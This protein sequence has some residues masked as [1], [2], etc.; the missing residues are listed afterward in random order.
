[1]R[2][3]DVVIVGA[4]LAGLCCALR[5]QERGVAC[6]IL[7]AGD[8]VGGRVRTDVVDGFLLDRGFQVLLTAYPEAQRV[9]DY[10]ALDLHA[11]YPGAMIRYG[12]RFVRFV[13]PTRRFWD[14]LRSAFAPIG[15]FNDKRLMLKLKKDVCRG[16]LD[17]LFRRPEITTLEALHAFGFSKEMIE[18]FFRPWLGGIFLEPNLT[19]SSR[20]LA[21]VY[22]MFALGDG[23][24]PAGGMGAIP[25]QIAARL[26][27]GTVRTRQRVVSAR[28]DRV[29]L[30][31]G[32]EIR[33]QAVVI[34]T[35]ESAANE[36]VGGELQAKFHGVRCLY[37]GADRAPTEEPVLYLDGSGAGPVNNLCVPSA[38]APTYAPA[39][40][41]LVS[42]TVLDAN[43]KHDDLEQAVRTQLREWFG[44]EVDAWR[45]LRTVHVPYAL[46]ERETLRSKPIARARGGSFVCG[47]HRENGSIQGAMVSGRATADAVLSEINVPTS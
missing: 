2:D 34:A 1:M 18:C 24:L 11:F 4:G 35:E 43:A 36:I 8:D 27:P 19:T 15:T 21:F 28:N 31:S 13:D 23:A 40:A 47:D 39:G 45:H 5:L 41:A 3:T 6:A 38:V 17:D 16:S 26:E 46:P 9:L 37:F 29:T 7:E 33:A 44:A 25:K 12:Q 42:A 32:E 22:R 10:D 30:V 14:G 20:M